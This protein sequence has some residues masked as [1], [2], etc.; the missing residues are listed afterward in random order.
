MD[1]RTKAGDMLDDICYR[2]YGDVPKAIEVVLNANPG[3]AAYGA[4]LPDGLI[5]DLPTL[6][7]VADATVSLWD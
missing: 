6:A 3:L 1:Y 2:Y 4:L 7:P 5:I